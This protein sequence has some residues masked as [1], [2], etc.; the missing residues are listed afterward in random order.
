MPREYAEYKNGAGH[1]TGRLRLFI[2]LL[3]DS[4]AERWEILR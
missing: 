2:C 3:M 1:F 4:V